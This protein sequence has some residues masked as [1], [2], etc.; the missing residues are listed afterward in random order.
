MAYMSQENKASKAPKIA[1]ICKQFGVKATLA[2]RHHSTLVLNISS[3]PIDFIGN[4]KAVSAVRN[5]CMP[6]HMEPHFGDHLDVNPY[7]YGEDFSGCALKFLTAIMEVM[8]EGNHDRS[9]ITIDYFDVGWYVDV[10][11]GKRNK[12]YE[13]KPLSVAQH[14]AL[15]SQAAA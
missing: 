2:V 4:A 3:G 9:D 11:V 10:N 13:F 6:E 12:P 1:K 8:H 7:H 5:A 14:K 15:T